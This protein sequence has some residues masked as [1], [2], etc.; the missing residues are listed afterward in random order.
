MTVVKFYDDIED[1]LLKFAVIIT[2]YQGHWVFCKHKERETLEVPGGHRE[3]GEDIEET[4]RR[5]L[6]EETGIKALPEE[7]E[8]IDSGMDGNTHF[9][10][11][12]LKR[13][14]PLEQIVLLPGETVDVKWATFEQVHQ[15]IREKKMCYV[16]ARQFRR[17]ESMLRERQD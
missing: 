6:Y 1:A 14:T 17:Q 12:C 10:Y 8:L 7:F 13:K 16:I 4:A 15:L 11:Y 2:K 9:D 5:E 3:P